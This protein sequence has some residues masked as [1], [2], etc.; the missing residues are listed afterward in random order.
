MPRNIV[1][2]LLFFTVI[3]FFAMGISGVC[4]IYK[5]LLDVFFKMGTQSGALK[6]TMKDVLY[7]LSSVLLM[8]IYYFRKYNK[9]LKRL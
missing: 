6:D 5:Y 8:I 7:A 4:E 2:K 3:F 9:N 1:D